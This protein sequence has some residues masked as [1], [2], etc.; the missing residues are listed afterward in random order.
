VGLSPALRRW[1]EVGRMVHLVA[2]TPNERT[3]R[4]TPVPAGDEAAAP[5]IDRVTPV[6]QVAVAAAPTHP[7]LVAL[8]AEKLVLDWP[9][10]AGRLVE[11]LR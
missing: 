3:G 9:D 6:H 1:V 5:N 11:E 7:A 4:Q 8:D 2:A 10:A